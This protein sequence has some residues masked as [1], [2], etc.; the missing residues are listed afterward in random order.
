MN[1]TS[2]RNINI[3]NTYIG[4]EFDDCEIRAIE[5]DVTN[6][7]PI[8]S[9]F[10]NISLE[11]DTIV[12]GTVKDAQALGEKMKQLANNSNFQ[13]DKV[14]L[15]ISSNDVLIRFTKVP[16]LQDDMI[17]NMIQYQSEDFFPVSIT[18][19][20]IDFMRL[21]LKEK[22]PTEKENDVVVVAAKNSLINAYTAALDIAKLH[23][24]EVDVSVLSLMGYADYDE[25]GTG[26]VQN[27]FKEDLYD[28]IMDSV[29][30]IANIAYGKIEL[31]ITKDFVPIFTKTSFFNCDLLNK[32]DS[33][34][35]NDDEEFQRLLDQITTEIKAVANY[36]F[37]LK[38]TENPSK[39]MLCGPVCTINGLVEY[40]AK[41]TQIRT[42][43]IY[44][45]DEALSSTAKYSA[46][47]NLALRG[48]EL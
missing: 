48:G 25:T 15:G 43:V 4:M 2:K 42:I 11:K 21:N 9:S 1:I 6:P 39:I 40:I 35:E 36:C 37:S 29:N 28:T 33:E 38:D 16:V 22:T 18:D 45:Q 20:S 13:S 41:Q 5:L 30:I 23:P 7:N 31:I 44:P 12:N 34:S 27:N 47:I 19:Y 17:R 8:I 10:G 26:A 32:P 14:I 46:A 24:Y 3:K